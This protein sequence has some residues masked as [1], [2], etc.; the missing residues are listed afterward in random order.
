V[1]IPNRGVTESGK[2]IRGRNRNLLKTWSD[3]CA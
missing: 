3:A 1:N 2:I